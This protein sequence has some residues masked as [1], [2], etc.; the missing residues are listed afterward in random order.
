MGKKTAATPLDTIESI[1][2]SF[3]GMWLSWLLCS[4]HSSSL[5]LGPSAFPVTDR[6]HYSTWA[7]HTGAMYVRLW[8]WWDRLCPSQCFLCGFL[9]VWMARGAHADKWSAQCLSARD[10]CEHQRTTHAGQL[11]HTCTLSGIALGLCA[12]SMHACFNRGGPNTVCLCTEHCIML[13]EQ[14]KCMVIPVDTFLVFFMV[15]PQRVLCVL[16]VEGRSVAHHL[17]AKCHSEV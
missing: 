2:A 5:Q 4:R 11:Q 10:Q 7:C 13:H 6:R 14:P 1:P 12:G 3:R 17:V 15:V 8:W 9:L 16:S